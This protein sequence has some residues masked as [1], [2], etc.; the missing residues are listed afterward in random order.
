MS[1][2]Y[3]DSSS[4]SSILYV[5]PVRSGQ[6]GPFDGS[7]LSDKTYTVMASAGSNGTISHAN[8]I[9]THGATTTFAVTPN[10]GYYIDTV[11]GCGGTLLGNIYTTGA[12][13]SDC[14]VTAS[15]A[16]NSYQLTVNKTGTGSGAV[17]VNTGTLSWSDSN[18]TAT[19]DYN[20]AVTLTATADSANSTFTG[21]GGDC[22]GTNS[23]SSITITADK[24]CTA[25]FTLRT[26]TVTASA[27]SGGAISPAD[28]TV[29]HGATASFVVIPEEGYHVNSITGCSGSLSDK[30]Y[31]TGT[32]T[33]DCYVYATFAPTYSVTID[34]YGTGSGT[35]NSSD[36]KIN[37]GADCTE[38]YAK[39]KQVT[40]AA[41]AS[42][43]SV[44]TGWS[45]DRCS[46]KALKCKVNING[47][48]NI[49]VRFAPKNQKKTTLKIQKPKN[50]KIMS[51]DGKINCGRLSK[52]CSAKYFTG[53]SIRLLAISDDGY[54][55]SEWKGVTC[56][57]SGSNECLINISGNHKVVPIFALGADVADPVQGLMI[58]GILRG[59]AAG[60]DPDNRLIM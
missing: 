52:L 36:K 41:K 39:A 17:A 5:W 25:T 55:V 16:M 7:G 18:G 6:S 27:G 19:Y 2:G 24:S 42:P 8:E 43:G 31:N 60:S 32:I 1:N 54:S 49:I 40:L 33:G 26:Y 4:K 29:E 22:T 51:D 46:V 20:A 56:A 45:G 53:D 48:Y 9:V 23:S 58:T 59:G 12:I 35:V 13:T 50:G 28:A 47:V 44:F 3:V 10:T 34:K 38:T 30:I 11:T 37:C 15:F 57:E 14:T 21:W